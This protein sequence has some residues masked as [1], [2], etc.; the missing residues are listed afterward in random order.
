MHR[1][2]RNRSSNSIHFNLEN[3]LFFFINHLPPYGD[4]DID[5]YYDDDDGYMMM[6]MVHTQNT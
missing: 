5:D 1:N 2:S 6:M 4:N 3:I